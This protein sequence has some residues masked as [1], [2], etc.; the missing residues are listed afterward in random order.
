MCIKLYTD[1]A[2]WKLLN[3]ELHL[4]RYHTKLPNLHF[5]ILDNRIYAHTLDDKHML[6]NILF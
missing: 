3:N 2:A 6:Y 1:I 4:V 5:Y